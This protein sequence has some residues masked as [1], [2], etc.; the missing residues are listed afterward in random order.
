MKLG[1]GVGVV[2]VRLGVKVELGEEQDEEE[3]NMDNE[4]P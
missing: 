3:D 2:G 4:V 1:V